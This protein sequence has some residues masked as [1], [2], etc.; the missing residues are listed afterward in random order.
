M[1]TIINNIV[2]ILF[3]IITALLIITSSIFVPTV[4][5]NFYYIQIDTLNICEETS[6]TKDEVKEAY[7]D[8]LDFLWK[9]TEFKT[10]KLK[11]SE[12]GK[13]H[14][15]D[16][17]VLFLLDLYVLIISFVLFV[18]ILILNHFKVIQLVYYKKLHPIFYASIT[19]LIVIIIIAILASLDFD[20][21]FETFHTVFFPGKSNWIFDPFQDEVIKILKEEYFMNCGIV[22]ACVLFVET[23]LGII[24]SVVKKKKLVKTNKL[25]PNF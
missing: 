10:G 1:K 12:E 17:K 6:L 13:S 2:T 25:E 14:F 18:A 23:T 5:R 4:D 22:I 21:A 16:C 15:E 24:I 7:D 11:Y 8:V 20:K 9:N 3:I 19:L